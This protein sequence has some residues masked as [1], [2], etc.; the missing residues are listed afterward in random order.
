MAVRD[1]KKFLANMHLFINREYKRGALD[2]FPTLVKMTASGFAE[3][4]KE[5]YN[6]IKEQRGTDWVY[7]TDAEF[8]LVGTAAL[9]AA[10]AWAEKSP[11]ATIQETSS[12][13]ELQ[14]AAKW[15]IKVPYETAKKAGVKALSNI[16]NGRGRRSLSG[17]NKAA[18]ISPRGSEVGMVKSAIHRGHEGSTTVGSAQLSAALQFLNQSANFGGFATSKEATEL[19]DIIKEVNLKF[20]T[21]GTKSGSK[22]SKVSLRENMAIGIEVVPRSKNPRGQQPYDWSNILPKL[23]DAITNYI[24]Q[25]HIEKQP[26][27]SSIEEN[28]EEVAA[29]IVLKELSRSKNARVVGGLKKPKGRKP[30]SISD[31]N[32][33]SSKP[34]AGSRKKGRGRVLSKVK[35]GIASS[36]LAL[37]SM[38]NQELP[39]TIEKNMNSPALVNR[40][41]RFANSV[42]VLNI[43]PTPKGFPSVGYS[44]DKFPYQTFELG[45]AQGSMERDPRKLIDRSIREIAAKL[46]IGRFYTRRI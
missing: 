22:A 26:G 35:K 11:N 32:K 5:G 20:D 1:T 36:P 28:A 29:Y 12:P 24:I 8:A 30:K 18:G 37:M 43:I 14:Y 42:Q 2:R 25:Q 45:Y 38:L 13:N 6:S 3:G 17:A 19:S 44:Y 9:A 7:L 41:G 33:S 16:L 10:K 23:T 46:A 27:S 15:D 39:Q 21:T 31:S 40:T 34:L 4:F